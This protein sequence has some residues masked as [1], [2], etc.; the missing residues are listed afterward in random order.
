LAVPRDVDP[1]VGELAGVRLYDLDT[2]QERLNGNL[3]D[4]RKEVPLVEAIIEEEVTQFEAWRHGAQLRPVLSAMHARG[5][6]IRRQEIER[7]LRRLGEKDPEVR[8]E[9]E[10]LSRALVTKL[11][12]APSTRLRNEID[13]VRS[14]LYVETIRELFGLHLSPSGDAEPDPA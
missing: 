13:P 3:A 11:L 7:V 14:R 8:D 2:L 12:H 4:R 10:A 6:A 1:Q 5:E 9:I